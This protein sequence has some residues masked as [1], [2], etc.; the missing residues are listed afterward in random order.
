MTVDERADLVS[1]L[2]DAG[3]SPYRADA[4]VTLLAF[5]AA[6][7]TEI[8][9]ASDV[10]DPRIYDVLRDL[11]DAG[12]IETYEQDLLYARAVSPDEV[13][14]DLR[15]RADR[16]SAAAEEIERRWEKPPME[17]TVV[18]LVKRFETVRNY[19]AEAIRGARN[20]VQVSLSATQYERLRPALRAAKANGANVHLSLHTAEA[21]VDTL[22]DREEIAAVCTEART[23]DKPAPFVAI[24]DRTES[25]FAPNRGSANEYGVLVDDRTHTYVL[26]WFF[27]TVL[28]DIWEVY[29]TA[30]DGETPTDYLDIR[31]CVRDIAP[32]LAE[33]ATVDV[34]VEG[35]DT[36]TGTD[37]T[38]QGTV[39][40]VIANGY[41]HDDEHA[42]VAIYSGQIG[43]IVDTDDGPVEIGGWGAMVEE[44]EAHRLTV[45]SVE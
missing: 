14:K 12:Y 32:L 31:Y 27:L 41:E 21:G 44:V 23:R 10:P 40:E 6:P 1:V 4:Y 42:P 7:A 3:F 29:Y 24:V 26:Y 18:S 5:G 15:T 45:L 30:D 16:F 19:A 25:C 35:V 34:L 17:V 28:W 20:Q 2:E 33:G 9:E 43:M 11:E 13:L 8:A 37:R 39:R 22:P 36:E 38:V